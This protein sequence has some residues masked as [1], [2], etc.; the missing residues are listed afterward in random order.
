MGEVALGEVDEDVGREVGGDEEG[1]E[2]EERGIG[3]G[4]S[5]IENYVITRGMDKQNTWGTMT[6]ILTL[7]HLLK[8]DVFT[9]VTA[10]DNW[11]RMS[12]HQ[13]DR[14]MKAATVRKGI[15]LR[16]LPNHYDVVLSR[17]QRNNTISSEKADVNTTINVAQKQNGSV[18]NSSAASF[19]TSAEDG[20]KFFPVNIQWQQD[21]CRMLHLDFKKSSN[22]QYDVDREIPLTVPKNIRKVQGDGNCLFRCLSNVVT[23]EERQHE[24]VRSAIVDHM[25]NLPSRLVQAYVPNGDVNEHL[26]RSKMN[27]SGIWGTETEIATFSHLLQINIYVYTPRYREWAAYTPT[28]D[29]TATLDRSIYIKNTGNNHFDPVR[30][31]RDTVNS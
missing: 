2:E 22:V 11:H 16:H 6:E 25:P 20:M 3:G 23:G 4:V 9:Y 27:R 10:Q 31:V 17:V 18:Q 15:Y 14:T 29:N 24:R 30:S 26:R 12:P 13:V 1:D 8:I 19:Q 5:S 28:F 7:S 21:T